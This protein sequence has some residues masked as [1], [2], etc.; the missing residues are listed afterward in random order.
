MKHA[1]IKFHVIDLNRTT[2]SACPLMLSADNTVFN[3][4]ELTRIKGKYYK[5]VL[6][7]DNIVT[8]YYR[9]PKIQHMIAH[10]YAVAVN[11]MRTDDRLAGDHKTA[12]AVNVAERVVRQRLLYMVKLINTGNI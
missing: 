9:D 6:E 3:D 2:A 8:L 5:A 11:W 10:R 7:S 12:Q 4:R 1:T